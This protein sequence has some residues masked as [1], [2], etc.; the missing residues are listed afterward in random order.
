MTRREKLLRLAELVRSHPGPLA[1][2]HGLEYIHIDDLYRFI[3]CNDISAF[4]LAA[5]DEVFRQQGMQENATIG[6]VKQFLELNQNE[7]HE[8]SCDCGGRISNET[9]AQRI[10]GLAAR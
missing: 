7:L 9:M 2:Y 8:F 6:N 10:E 3:I 4:G 1:L 5:R